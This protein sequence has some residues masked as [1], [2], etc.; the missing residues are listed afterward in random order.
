[1]P[2]PGS[3]D[4]LHGVTIVRQSV[5]A[6]ARDAALRHIHRNV[7]RHGLSVDDLAEWIWRTPS[8]F[9]HLRW[10]PEITQ[11]LD[12]VPAEFRRGQLCEPQII[13]QFPDDEGS[14]HELVPHQDEEP[15]WA[16]GRRYLRIVGVPLTPWHANNGGLA[17]WANGDGPTTLTLEAG[18]VV[19]MSPDLPHSGG[20]NREGSIR[21]G[22]YFR[23][24]GE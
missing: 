16:E 22:V 21:Y 11:L 10:D 12:H 19:V 3:R 9:P 23:F 2:G 7:A 24:L 18:D 13:L 6:E 5:P 14:D 1:V 17:V 8:W 20:I 15:P 4:P